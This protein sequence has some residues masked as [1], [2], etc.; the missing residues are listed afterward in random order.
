MDAETLGFNKI[1]IFTICVYEMRPAALCA[2]QLLKP[3]NS[4]VEAE[5]IAASGAPGFFA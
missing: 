2:Y 4:S 1:G 5:C 3:E